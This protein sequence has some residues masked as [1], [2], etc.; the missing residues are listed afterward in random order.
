MCKM[1]NYT[2]TLSIDTL[3]GRRNCEVRYVRHRG[4][5]SELS[6]IAL[7]KNIVLTWVSVHE[8]SNVKKRKGGVKNE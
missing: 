6:T 5:F 3:M 8:Y 4:D 2:E 1:I 7:R